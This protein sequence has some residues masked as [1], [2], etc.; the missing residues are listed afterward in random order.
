MTIIPLYVNHAF[1]I[2]SSADGHPGGFLVLV[3]VNSVAK[4]TEMHIP[5]GPMVF[6]GYMSSSGTA[7]SYGS[8]IFVL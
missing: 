6:S 7:G 3:I 2:H 4:N 8:S 1:F 5:V